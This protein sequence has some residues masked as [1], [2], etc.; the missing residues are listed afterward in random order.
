MT[1]VAIRFGRALV[2][3]LLLVG[4]VFFTLAAN[5]DPAL[6][7][8]GEDIDAQT[9]AAFRTK[10]GLDYPL[11]KQFLIYLDGL[12]HFD[13]GLSFR[14]G[15]PASELIMDRLPATLSLMAPTAF[16]S[17]ALGVPVGIYAAMHHGD[18]ADR[19]TILAAVVALA[20]PSFLLGLLIMYVFSVWL[21]WLDPSGI[22]G[23]TSYIMPVATMA[24]SASAIFARF[25]RSAMVEVMSHPMIET[26]Q[27]SGL[28][29][30][31]IQRVHALPNVLL[32]LITIAALEFG[33]L[34][35]YAVIVE[36]VFGWPGVGRLLIESVAGRDY[37][38]VQA[39]VMMTG[40]T[41]ILAN[42]VADLAYGFVDPRI[43][44]ARGLRLWRKRQE[45]RA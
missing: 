40:V 32:P 17:I 28:T 25:T 34:I 22:T 43:A 45:V 23:W 3:L 36:S 16:L 20:I 44:D 12:V 37:A 7:R 5:G 13:L 38:V 35:T 27:A 11:W 24:I 14:T 41:M 39:A 4:F 19:L 30:G 21:G 31:L 15:R 8:F 2:T 26:A 42:F 29:R 18:R 10:W 6:A 1:W 33:N 9:L